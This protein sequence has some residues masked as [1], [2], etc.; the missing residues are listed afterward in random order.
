M[1]GG[2]K[3]TNVLSRAAAVQA[4]TAPVDVSVCTRMTANEKAD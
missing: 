4:R 1:F 2:D 3:G